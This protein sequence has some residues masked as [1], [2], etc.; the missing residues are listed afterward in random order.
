MKASTVTVWDRGYCW[1]QPFS[2]YSHC[3]WLVWSNVHELQNNAVWRSSLMWK[4][5]LPTA[6]TGAH[7]TYKACMLAR[8]RRKQWLSWYQFWRLLM[9]DNSE[10]GVDVWKHYDE[11]LFSSSGSR[12]HS[13][14]G[15]LCTVLR[16]QQKRNNSWSPESW[17]RILMQ[18]FA[19]AAWLRRAHPL[20]QDVL[21]HWISLPAHLFSPRHVC[22]APY[23]VDPVCPVHSTV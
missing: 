19:W 2:F 17:V 1:L 14:F 23:S 8:K 7:I 6:C 13:I 18:S 10:V 11:V 3:Y 21:W 20:S 16:T 4:M 15:S 5:C 12:S 9:I 22:R